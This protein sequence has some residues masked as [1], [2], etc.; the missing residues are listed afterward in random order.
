MRLKKFY[1]EYMDALSLFDGDKAISENK[2]AENLISELA[3]P[4]LSQMPVEMVAKQ[5]VS[6]FRHD[7]ETMIA[8]ETASQLIPLFT[9]E[10]GEPIKAALEPHAH[11]TGCAPYFI[12]KNLFR[13]VDANA[14]AVISAAATSAIRSLMEDKD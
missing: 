13:E 9:Q 14:R 5:T 7:M 10:E 8:G 12:D 3:P 2:S 4:V 1:R 6:W 11:I